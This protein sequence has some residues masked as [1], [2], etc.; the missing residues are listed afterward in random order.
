MVQFGFESRLEGLWVFAGYAICFVFFWFG[1][2][3][4]VSLRQASGFSVCKV[5]AGWCFWKGQACCWL[6]KAG[7]LLALEGRLAWLVSLL[8]VFLEA[9]FSWRSLCRLVWTGFLVIDKAGCVFFASLEV[10]QYFFSISPPLRLLDRYTYFLSHC[11]CTACQNCK[12]FSGS[13]FL[14]P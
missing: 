2:R 5:L 1:S 10:I 6:W 3:F 9:G 13:L 8:L 14:S 12:P 11:F 4:V 7:L